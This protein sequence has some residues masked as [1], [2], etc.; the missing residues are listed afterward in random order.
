MR[1]LIV[2]SGGREHTLAWAIKKSPNVDELYV[3]PGNGGTS[4]IAKNVPVTGDDLDALVS[5][6]VENEVDLTVVGPEAPLV[7]GIVDRFREAGRRCFGPTRAAARLE[8]SK[9]FAKE[10]MKRQAVPTADFEIFDDATKARSYIGSVDF[11]IVIKADGLAAG[12]GVIVAASAEEA[13]AAIDDIMAKKKFGASGDSVV[14][15]SC[16]EGEEVSVH[17]IC[18]GG[19]AVLLPSSQDHKRIFD[20]DKGPN[21]G[22]MGAYSPVPFLSDDERQTIYETIIMRTLKG[23][24]AEGI[25]YSGVLYAGLMIT[26]DGPKVLEFNVR[27]GD[28]ETQVLLPL[29]KSDMFEL[30]YESA[31][32]NSPESIEFYSDRS[33][34][35]V[36]V[37]S[38]GYPGSY[39]KGRVIEGLESIED[40]RRV[41]FHAGTKRTQSGLVT[42][43]G[44]VLAVTAW[45]EAL[46]GA[47]GHA[48]EGVEM[49]RF[50][51]AYWRRD[52]GRR[53]L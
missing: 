25:P 2:G 42:S 37:A 9:V 20:D 34:A 50:N 45:D 53:G 14:V 21:T 39:E 16:L 32:G 35:A 31:G 44:R 24:E 5:F 23:M 36:V 51:G 4:Q 12:K 17:A 7:D 13:T 10:F 52:I 41:V 18:G 40:D 30:L 27:F 11:P 48:Y 3:A 8:G 43:G 46:S 28:P 33:A 47:L 22:G 19:E 1:A 29:V 26:R 6:A 15:E 49:V 38:K